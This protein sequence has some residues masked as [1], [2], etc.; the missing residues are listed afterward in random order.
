MPEPSA[1]FSASPPT[2]TLGTGAAAYEG[3]VAQARDESWAERLFAKDPSLWSSRPAR[4]ARPS[5]SGSAGSTP[6]PTS[7]TGSPPSRAS[8]TRSSTRASRP[9]S[10]P[11]WAAAASPRTSSHGRSASIEGYLALRILDSTDPASVAA[12]R[13]RPRPARGRSF[14]VATQVRHDDR[15]ERL[16]RRR[17]GP[18]RGGARADPAPRLRARP[19]SY[20]AAIT[21]PGKSVEAIAHHDDFREVFLNPPDIGG[22]YSGADVRRARPGVAHRARPRRAARV[23]ARRCSAPAASRTRPSTPGVSLGLAIGTLAKAGRDKLTFLADDE[24][25]SFGAWVE[26]LIAEST[27]KHGVGIVPV[28]LEPLGAVEAYGADRAFVRIALAGGDGRRPRRAGRRA[29]GGRPSGHPDRASPTRST[30]APSSSAGRSRPRSPGAVLGIDPF[31]QPNVEEAKQLTRDV[32]G[33]GAIGRRAGHARRRADRRGRRPDP[34]RRRRRCASPRGDGDVVGEL[35]PPPR[36]APAERL[37]R[38]S[39]RSSPRPPARDEAHRAHPD[40]AAR[41]DRRATTAGYG[42]RFLH[43]TG[44]LHKGGAPIGWFLQLTADH[45]ADRPDPG[46]AVHVRPAH[47]RPGRGRLRG[48]RVA[49]PADPAGPPRRRPGRRP[50]RPRAG[51]RRRALSTPARRPDAMRIGFIGLGRMGA[52]MVRRLAP[53]R[54]RDRR[55]QPDA[56]EDAGDRRRGRDRVV[57]DRGAGR[58]AREAARG[59]DHGPGR[60]RHRGPDRRAARAPRAGRHDHR[61][62]QHELPRRRRAATPSSR[63]RASTTSTPGRRAG[64]GASRSATA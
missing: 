26:Q 30:S 10:S 53:R 39:R 51:A 20:F 14:I 23:G 36:P 32:L 50:G 12:T 15:A 49:R 7:P 35:R 19:A 45:P 46:L 24:I 17:L 64:S 25:A 18:R 52:N 22:R 21:D 1:P 61:R 33:G 34:P 48:D 63:R 40:A 60:R 31:D 3:A 43:S 16:P 44:Q 55:L 9:R 58:R 13:R 37:P 27:G 38:A 29:R 2:L 5:R 62:R 8:A 11:A 59:L 6:R 4:P 42:P 41:R 56:G 57:L 54:P 28:D 47:R